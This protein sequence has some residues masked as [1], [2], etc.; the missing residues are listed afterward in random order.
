MTTTLRVGILGHYG[1]DNLG[2]EAIVQAVIENVRTRMPNA[3]LVCFSVNPANTARRHGVTAYPLTRH[4]V[5]AAVRSKTTA[6]AAAAATTPDPADSGTAPPGL[7]WLKA[8]PGMRR[9]VG[10]VRAVAHLP[11][12]LWAELSFVRLSY[13]RL[14]KVDLLVVAGSNQFLDN[15]GG[16]WAFPYA[17]LKW[18]WLGRLAG[19]RVAF[20]SVGAGPLSSPWSKAFVRLAIRAA[21]LLSF[22]D[23]ASRQLIVSRWAGQGALVMPDLAFGLRVP[24]HV[25]SGGVGRGRARVGINPMPVHDARY[26]YAPNTAAYGAYVRQLAAL[27]AHLSA[28]GYSWYFYATQPKDVNVMHDVAAQLG[29]QDDSLAAQSPEFFNPATVN[30]LMVRLRETDLV[31]AT[32]F[33]GVVLP[34]TLGI[35]ALG[36]CYHRKTADVLDAVGL[37]AYH[38]EIDAFK[39]DALMA[40]LEQLEQHSGAL[41]CML[42]PKAREFRGQLDA[43]Y[44]ALL[45]PWLKPAIVEA[46]PT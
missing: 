4:A 3:Q 30:E 29:S 21:D 8:V 28:K 39:A 24:V 31:V 27:C 18:S 7:A 2:D 12:N 41:A 20:L 46:H 43:H 25:P 45:A 34:L 16:V 13:Q 37:G 26:W 22:R 33:H 44:D 23:E 42:Q 14:R 11:S 36:I 17:M 9:A 1:N 19:A 6:T 35:P 40:K 10:I 32:R 5:Q 38:M 15:F